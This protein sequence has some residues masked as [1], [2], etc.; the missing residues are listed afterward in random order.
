MVAKDSPNATIS[1]IENSQEFNVESHRDEEISESEDE[2]NLN[3]HQQIA[4]LKPNK[5]MLD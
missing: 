1:S 5:V 3:P 2:K 4:S